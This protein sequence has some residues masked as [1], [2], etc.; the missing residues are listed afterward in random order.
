MSLGSFMR[1][2][3]NRLTVS[4]L[5][6]IGLGL[7]PWACVPFTLFPSSSQ[8]C[9][10]EAGPT[11]ECTPVIRGLWWVRQSSDGSAERCLQTSPPHSPTQTASDN[12]VIC[13]EVCKKKRESKLACALINAECCKN[14]R[15]WKINHDQ[16]V[17]VVF[18][19]RASWGNA[20]V[21][22]TDKD[23][24]GTQNFCEW[25][26][27]FSRECNIFVSKQK[28]SLGGKSYEIIVSLSP[29]FLWMLNTNYTYLHL[30]IIDK[31]CLI[32][33]LFVLIFTAFYH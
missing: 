31:L 7:A 21:L 5:P 22:Q 15:W 23:S 11:F 12:A 28:C 13:D 33:I 29:Y 14:I 20:K 10:T 16:T 9:E 32:N 26:Q 19:H 8:S 2:V 18:V 3:L 17:G 27:S 1:S 25:M 30:L 6:L 4:L 24:W